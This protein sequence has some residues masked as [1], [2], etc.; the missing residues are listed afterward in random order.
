MENYTVWD[1]QEDLIKILKNKSKEEA[2]DFLLV[3]KY[4]YLT[5]ILR[6]LVKDKDREDI[7]RD[8]SQKL[9]EIR[10]FRKL[11]SSLKNSKELLWVK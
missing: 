10:D 7:L 8:I 3:D 9:R 6:D 5:S 2:L 11:I 4:V 1:T